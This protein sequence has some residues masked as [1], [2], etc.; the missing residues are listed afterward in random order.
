MAFSRRNYSLNFIIKLLIP[1]LILGT[2]QT[3]VSGE[4][5]HYM[6]GVASIRDFVVP[7]PGFYYA[8]YNLL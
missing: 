1:F 7:E 2:A 4:L 5:G 8:Q 3:T 6:P